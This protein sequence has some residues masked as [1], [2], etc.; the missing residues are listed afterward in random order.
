MVEFDLESG[1][2][3]L[4]K[5]TKLAKSKKGAVPFFKATKKSAELAMYVCKVQ[6]VNASAKAALQDMHSAKMAGLMGRIR[7]LPLFAAE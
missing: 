6:G 4:I 1:W 5:L 2:F 3:V 7:D